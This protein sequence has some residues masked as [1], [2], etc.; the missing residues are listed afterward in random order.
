MAARSNNQYRAFKQAKLN[1]QP[2]VRKLALAR[3]DRRGLLIRLVLESEFQDSRLGAMQRL[4]TF[5]VHNATPQELEFY[6]KLALKEKVTAI[7]VIAANRVYPGDRDK[8]VESV[9]PDV[10]LM[11]AQMTSSRD[12]LRRLVMDPDAAVKAT[13]E[14]S[15]S[16]K[17]LQENFDPFSVN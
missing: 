4:A 13:A 9:F 2:E 10:R 11:V 15:F 12:V 7:R 17:D 3:I 5:N 14:K 1:T 16:K 8:L 6:L